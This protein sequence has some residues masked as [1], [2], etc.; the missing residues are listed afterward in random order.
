MISFRDIRERAVHCVLQYLRPFSAK[1]KEV[2]RV[3]NPLKHSGYSVYRLLNT[4]EL[5]IFLTVYTRIC[6]SY[7]CWNK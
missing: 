4:E 5:C 7:D 2:N 1:S 3:I 6:V